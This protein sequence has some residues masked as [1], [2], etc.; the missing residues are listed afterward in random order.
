MSDYITTEFCCIS[1]KV[2][3]S[4]SLM[5]E[6]WGSL[7]CLRGMKCSVHDPEAVGLNPGRV[8]LRVCSLSRLDLN[9]KYLNCIPYFLK[10]SQGLKLNPVLNLTRINLP[11]Q[12]NRAY[13]IWVSIWALSWFEPGWF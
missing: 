10:Y 3:S 13:C 7:E 8:K 5:I 9:Q 4:V 6:Q 11:I 2:F 1:N 12:I